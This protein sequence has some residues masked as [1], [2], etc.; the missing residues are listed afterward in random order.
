MAVLNVIQWAQQIVNALVVVHDTFQGCVHGD[1]RLENVLV[2][3]R[4]D[5][6]VKC[7]KELCHHFSV[8]FK[9]PKYIFIY[10]ETQTTV[11]Y[12]IILLVPEK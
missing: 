2:S 8:I 10:V 11:L 9:N 1:L 6:L 5:V 3:E 7:V 4:C 12:K